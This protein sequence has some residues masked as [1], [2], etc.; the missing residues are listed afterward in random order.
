MILHFVEVLKIITRKYK[1][2]S[3]KLHETEV[4][5]Q[6]GMLMTKFKK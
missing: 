6:N 2:H 5:T 3:L 4:H 1:L